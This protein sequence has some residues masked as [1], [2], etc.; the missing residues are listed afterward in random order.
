MLEHPISSYYN[1]YIIIMKSCCNSESK[2]I[3]AHNNIKLVE[4]WKRI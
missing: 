3:Q 4:L 2:S 1:K